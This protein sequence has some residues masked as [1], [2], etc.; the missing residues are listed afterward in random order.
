MRLPWITSR[1]DPDDRRALHATRPHT[2]LV[3]SRCCAD[4]LFGKSPAPQL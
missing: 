1:P 2:I 4:R 3:R